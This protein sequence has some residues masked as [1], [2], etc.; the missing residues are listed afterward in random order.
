MVSAR[1]YGV[2]V[3]STKEKPPNERILFITTG[4]TIA[5]SRGEEGFS[6][7]TL[8]G[9]DLLQ[10]VPELDG[11]GQIQIQPVLN[12]DSSNMQPENWVTMA[13]TVFA[14]RDDYDGGA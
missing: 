12:I 11:L 14:A 5:S 9:A 13:E 6:P 7:P 1:R 8:A 2:R 10:A 4:G 3:L